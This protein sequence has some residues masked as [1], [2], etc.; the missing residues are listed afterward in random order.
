MRSEGFREI[1]FIPSDFRR[2][3]K[4]LL[5][6]LIAPHRKRAVEVRQRHHGICSG[7]RDAV[8]RK[9][10]PP[11]MIPAVLAKHHPAIIGVF[12]HESVL[13]AFARI[14]PRQSTACLHPGGHLH[15]VTSM[16]MRHFRQDSNFIPHG[17]LPQSH[18]IL[19]VYNRG[20]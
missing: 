13:P 4:I 16:E 14:G 12:P 8:A 20:I 1:L 11:K 19:I 6:A 17:L 18:L 2:L 7:K 5:P 10:V 15:F 3:I 9:T